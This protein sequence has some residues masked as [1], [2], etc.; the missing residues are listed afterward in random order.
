MLTSEKILDWDIKEYK[1]KSNGIEHGNMLCSILQAKRNQGGWKLSHPVL[2]RKKYWLPILYRMLA[3]NWRERASFG[4]V[5]KMLGEVSP[6]GSE[7]ELRK[8]TSKEEK[9]SVIY[10]RRIELY[11]KF[12][13][14]KN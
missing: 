7:P 13:D 1:Q 6:S 3:F 4:E 14:Y 5:S 11:L 12:K 9:E 10:R 8:N 2:D